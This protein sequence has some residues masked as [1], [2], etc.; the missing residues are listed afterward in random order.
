MKKFAETRKEMITGRPKQKE[1]TVK[2]RKLPEKVW[3]YYGET[4]E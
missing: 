3:M 2:E 1:K 4:E